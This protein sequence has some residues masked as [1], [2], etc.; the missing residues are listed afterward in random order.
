MDIRGSIV[1]DSIRNETYRIPIYPANTVDPTG[2]GDF[3]SGGFLEGIGETGD[4]VEA[5][6]RG[7]ISASFCVENWG[8]FDM[9]NVKSPR[10]KNA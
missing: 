3:Y 5:G 2:A 1:H 6:L 10:P 7:T 4:V 8:A 9:L